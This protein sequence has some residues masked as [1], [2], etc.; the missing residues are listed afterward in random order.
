MNTRV[1]LHL[2]NPLPFCPYAA[3]SIDGGQIPGSGAETVSLVG[4]SVPTPVLRSG[5][6]PQHGQGSGYLPGKRVSDEL[7]KMLAIAEL[8][9]RVDDFRPLPETMEMICERVAGMPA[10]DW[11]TISLLAD[12]RRETTAWASPGIKR[13][14]MEWSR[15]PRERHK[16]SWSPIYNAA[17]SGRPILITNVAEHPEFALLAE[18]ARI[19]GFTGAAYIP[20]MSGGRALGTLNCYTRHAHK[21]TDTEVRL[22]QTVARLAGLAAE[23]AMI[24]DRQHKGAAEIQRL[25]D[26]LSERNDELS[27]LIQAQVDLAVALAEPGRDA[28]EAICR[29]V[30]LRLGA[31]V[32]I[33][34]TDGKAR[35]YAGSEEARAPISQTLVRR[36]PTRL[37]ALPDGSVVS[38]S[39][40]HRIGND[41]PLGLVLISPP[42]EAPAHAKTV[43][44]KH[45]L[46][47]LAF[48]LETERA[49]RTMRDVAR[50]SVLYA[51]T[52]GA[53]SAY[54][55]HAAGAFVDA[56][57][58]RLRVAFA[59][60]ADDVAAS[61]LA[62]RLNRLPRESRCL[63]AA[64][65]K[66]GVIFLMDDAPIEQLRQSV[67]K[68][69]EQCGAADR[70]V[71]LSD[72]FAD[73]TSAPAAL[74]Q[75]RMVSN[76]VAANRTAMYE[77][78]GPTS[79]LLKKLSPETR[80]AFVDKL[81]GPL[82]AYDR[83]RRGDLV[84]SVAAYLR[85]RGSLRSASAELAIHPNTLQLR[86]ARAASLTSLDFHD[87]LQLGLVALAVNW[88]LLLEDTALATAPVP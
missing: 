82:L 30:S 87:P 41:P 27:D 54:Q 39:S 63:A 79:E 10:C 73:I 56:T 8:A 46:A 72:V 13:E 59:R 9:V 83:E 57:G 2:I 37:A 44:L 40:S 7:D 36:D 81:I 18:G 70:P 23:T 50:P 64:P 66:D 4:P 77:D 5:W 78:L 25:S 22:L 24:A 49:D 85:H 1:C 67:H 55:A 69:L 86:L 88:H 16:S 80:G 42:L 74:E 34:G 12:D 52:R 32:M 3:G 76:V 38:A 47:L 51:L 43:F 33:C 53:L 26:E 11:L 14:F 19:Q 17:S 61:Q 48:D 45:A 62:H 84:A 28:A 75:A 58:Q 20:I 29:V 6:E 60:T 68:L 35:A 71:G 21:H 31:S 65:E 15:Q